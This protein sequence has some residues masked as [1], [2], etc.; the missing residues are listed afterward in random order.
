MA[1]TATVRLSPRERFAVYVHFTKNVVC[2][3]GRE[4]DEYED[5]WES[6]KLPIIDAVVES[7]GREQVPQDFSDDASGP[8]GIDVELTKEEI[9]YLV[10]FCTRPMPGA[11]VRLVKPVRAKFEAARD[12]A[13]LKAV[14][15]E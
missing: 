7:S 9:G 1:K 11:L 2:Q 10:K 13:G 3:T 14:A 12:Q 6:L 5:L 15:A 8:E 4:Q